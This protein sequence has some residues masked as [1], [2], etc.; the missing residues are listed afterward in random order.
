MWKYASVTLEGAPCVWG[1]HESPADIGTS[2]GQIALS[3]PH[4]TLKRHHAR[5]FCVLSCQLDIL[6]YSIQVS[7]LACDGITAARALMAKVPAF[8]RASWKV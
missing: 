8:T 6:I 2:V 1:A 7:I 3:A 4:S 5:P